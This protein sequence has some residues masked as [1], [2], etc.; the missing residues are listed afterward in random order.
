M[1]KLSFFIL[2][3]LILCGCSTAPLTSTP[4]P[5]NVLII[6]TQADAPAA[7]PKALTV[8]VEADKMNG[9]SIARLPTFTPTIT[10]TPIPYDWSP[11]TCP[12]MYRPTEAVVI[13]FSGMSISADELIKVGVPLSNGIYHHSHYFLCPNGLSTYYD[14]A[15]DT[16]HSINQNWDTQ[17]Y[18]LGPISSWEY[19]YLKNGKRHEPQS[20]DN[21]DNLWLDLSPL[22]E[23]TKA[24]AALLD[25]QQYDQ[26]MINSRRLPNGELF[27]LPISAYIAALQYNPELFDDAGLNYPPSI[28]G[29]PYRFPDGSS[30]P[31]DW[32]T[33]AR[34][35]RL[36]TLDINNRNA[37]EPGFDAKNIEQYGFTWGDNFLLLYTSLYWGADTLLAPGGSPGSYKAQISNAWKAGWQWTYDGIHGPQPFIAINPDRTLRS[38]EYQRALFFQSGQAA[39]ALQVWNPPS[40]TNEQAQHF[41]FAVLPSYQEKIYNDTSTENFYVLGKSDHPNEAFSSVAYIIEH[42][43]PNHLVCCLQEEAVFEHSIPVRLADRRAYFEL[44]KQ[45]Y[46]WVTTWHAFL[47]GLDYTNQSFDESTTPNLYNVWQ[48][49]YTFDERLRAAGIDLTAEETKLEADLT[50]I[51]NQ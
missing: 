23:T 21:I 2:L 20:N 27:S 50:I 35:S 29:E 18:I 9:G 51:F 44:Q 33:V 49:F 13:W 16:F 5:H 4:I 8:T 22:M 32:D 45:R 39:M 3:T 42:A 40:V 17:P 30:A 14:V 6:P 38:R 43:S 19:S 46:P 26:A 25:P 7:T 11:Y 47:S 37:T 48:R 34:V 36:L 31:W 24:G 28:V 12:I 41:Q 1:K 10:N 15:Y